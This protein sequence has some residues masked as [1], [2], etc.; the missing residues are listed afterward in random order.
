MDAPSWMEMIKRIGL[1]FTYSNHVL[2]VAL[3][4]GRLV[5]CV[6]LA[7]FL[8]GKST[9]NE[10]K[11]AL[12][13]MLTLVVY[14]FVYRMLPPEAVPRE[15]IP[16]MVVLLREIFIGLT[17]GLVTNHVFYAIEM[18]GR[19]IDTARGSNMA[20]VM[21]PQMEGRATPLGD[22]LYQFSICLVFALGGHRVY[23]QT[24]AMSFELFPLTSEIAW[25]NPSVFVY[26]DSVMRMGGDILLLAIGIS[27][28][29]QAAVFIVDVVFGLL[30]RVA[31]QL[32]A[33]F[34]AMPVK[35]MGAL[36]LLLISMTMVVA[37]LE[38]TVQMML[39]ETDKALRYLTM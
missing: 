3:V 11:M 39:E 32:N 37:K 33:Y 1:E 7:P 34:M 38:W 5:P 21:V 12:I 6:I 18:V 35:A 30:N 36:I 23:I 16:Y 22:L 28:P 2:A 4:M 14:P 17:M 15:P 26:F 20:E 9:P 24:I 31:P 13:V 10:V 27:L 25:E 19:M 8:G 29:A